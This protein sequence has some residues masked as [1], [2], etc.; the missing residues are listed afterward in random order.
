MNKN[1]IILV[2]LF[3]LITLASTFLVCMIKIDSLKNSQQSL[4]YEN[5]LNNNLAPIDDISRTK[6]ISNVKYLKFTV[7]RKDMTEVN[8]SE[9]ENNP[10]MILFFDEKSEDSINVLDKVESI[11][12]K[13]K[14][15]I[16]FL[17]IDIDKDANI[18]LEKNYSMEIFYDFYG[19][20]IR[21]YNIVEYPSMIY[22]TDNNEIFNAKTGV[23]SLD[24][25]EANLDILSNNI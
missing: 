20:A 2:A 3:L 21:N 9:Y 10:V 24:A 18:E 23:T 14:D 25:L 17:V 5:S 8:L 19:E 4:A 7:Y 15:Q 1:L 22:I 12:D 6:D 16:K 11:Y 13:Y